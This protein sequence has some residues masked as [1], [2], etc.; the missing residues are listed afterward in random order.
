[1]V[2]AVGT[3]AGLILRRALRVIFVDDPGLKLICLFLAIILW[4]YIDGEIRMARPALGTEG[5]SSIPK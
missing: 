5:V 4:F 2:N 1:M 3:R